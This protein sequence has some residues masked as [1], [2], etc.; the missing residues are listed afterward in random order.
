[1]EEEMKKKQKKTAKKQKPDRIDRLVN[2]IDKYY[3]RLHETDDKLMGSCDSMGKDFP[4]VQELWSMFESQELQESRKSFFENLYEL[5]T[6]LPKAEAAEFIEAL[7]N[8]AYEW[9]VESA[10][11][12]RLQGFVLGLRLAGMPSDI[13]KRMAK[14]WRLGRPRDDEV[15]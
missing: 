13:V 1:V 15:L 5:K 9:N 4:A 12:P 14:T 6:K 11:Y 10:D 8:Y 7:E 2:A 3:F